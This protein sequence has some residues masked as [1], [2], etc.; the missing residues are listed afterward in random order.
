MKVL[1]KLL[2]VGMAGAMFA[3][4]S[5]DPEFE[6]PMGPV[7]SGETVSTTLEL[8]VPAMKSPVT[9]IGTSQT[10]AAVDEAVSVAFSE[11]SDVVTRAETTTPTAAESALK[12][13]FIFQFD[14]SN[15]FA[16]IETVDLSTVS[17]GT[18]LSV[19]VPLTG[20]DS[21]T[22]YAIANIDGTKIDQTNLTVSKFEALLYEITA[23]I[24][25][26]NND[27][28]PMIGYWSGSTKDTSKG[29]PKIE[30]K[31]M[32][33]KISFICKQDVPAGH[34]FSLT[35]V[36]LCSVSPQSVYKAPAA[37][38]TVPDAT[39]VTFIDYAKVSSA[40]LGETYEWYVPE[41]LRGT[42]ADI[43]SPSDKGE[44][45]APTGSTFIE[46]VGSYN[47][48]L[49]PSA[50]V[51]FR[52]F[53]GA[54]STTDFN[55]ARNHKYAITATVKGNNPDDGRVVVATDLCK[56]PWDDSE[57]TANCYMVSLA[58]HAYKFKATVS[59]NGATTPASTCGSQNAPE[60]K[61]L[62]LAPASA[63]VLWETGGTNKIIKSV[64]YKNDWVYF[65]TAGEA[66]D[67]ITEG[68][69]VIAVY[70][71]SG[72]ILWSWHIW[73]TAYDPV[74]EHHL[75]KTR[76]VTASGSYV[77]LPNAPRE[78]RV[79]TRNLGASSTTV[80]NVSSFG[81]LYQWGRKD[82]FVGSSATSGTTFVTTYPNTW[83]I[84][85]ASTAASSVDASITYAIQHPTTFL[86]QYNTT[87]Y[88]WVA[89]SAVANQRD[90]LWGNPNTATTYP[91]ASLGS[92]SIYD[93]CP[94]GW[95]VAPQDTWTAFTANG[96]NSST[97]S[98]TTAWQ[99][100]GS[101]N[102]GWTFYYDSTDKSTSK[103]SYYPAT[104]YR[105][106]STGALESVG[107]YGFYWS[108]SSYSAGSYYAGNLCFH[109]GNVSPL[110][111]LVR[112]YGFPVRCVH[113]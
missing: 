78:V 113:E 64:E 30:M 100:N 53:P 84:V 9:A 14:D 54:N 98:G 110:Y 29:T 60:I 25:N 103:T 58:G 47:D 70:N 33:A 17:S 7:G 99:V 77:A 23:E 66:G 82:P 40:T 46:V 108:S 80:A 45:K 61:P 22:V 19:N 56:N 11:D 109:S 62:T 31:R 6:D 32:V 49:N 3:A 101:F 39:K 85:A 93:P 48:G 36:Q 20:F 51:T 86:T 4:C 42:V 83:P 35:S 44:N 52:I 72:T 75:Y 41:N 1:S 73:S 74:A 27:G 34:S 26:I 18:T 5:K 102:I 50:N 13:L 104:G 59:G 12:K 89:A 88:D 76:K 8:S 57:A 87:T 10:R 67:A 111:N 112:A 21:S 96:Q 28:L 68:N 105:N 95:R 81:L 90:N 15:N 55:I 65:T 106:Y 43:S 24:N 91:N 37:G 2:L 69:A 94:P 63:K 16:K 38:T 92:K 79:M 97:N 71:A 107:T